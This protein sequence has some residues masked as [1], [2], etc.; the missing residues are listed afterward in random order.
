ML[1]LADSS[2]YFIGSQDQNL[3][4][5][6]LILEYFLEQKEIGKLAFGI[7]TINALYSTGLITGLSIDL[8]SSYFRSMSV[9]NG[10][11]IDGYRNSI[12]FGGVDIDRVLEGLIGSV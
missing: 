12:N 11:S 1:G 10:W 4:D 7:D 6:K 2:L 5:M 3:S 8:G 9:L